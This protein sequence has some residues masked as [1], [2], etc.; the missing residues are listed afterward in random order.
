MAL[1]MV[2]GWRSEGGGAVV[3]SGDDGAVKRGVVVMD[4]GGG[5]LAC[6]HAGLATAAAGDGRSGEGERDGDARLKRGSGCC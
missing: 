3:F 1:V 2:D 4:G 5:W 6:R